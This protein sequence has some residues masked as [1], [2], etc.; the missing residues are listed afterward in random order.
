[1]TILKGSWLGIDVG[2]ARGKV[3]SF[4]LIE[5]DGHGGTTVCFEQGPARDPYPRINTRQA[6]IALAPDG[7]PWRRPTYL[8][9]EVEAEICAILDR[10]V[11]VGRWLESRGD[12]PSAV[13]VDAPV[14]FATCGT[15]RLTEQQ[16]TDTFET[17][18]RET[19]EAQL[20]EQSDAFL[21]INAF[22]KCVGLT[23]YR[24]LA[25]RV[26][27][28]LAGATLETIAA[29]TCDRDVISGRLRETFPSD[30]Y[31][32]ANGTAGTLSPE[33]RAVLRRLVE[34]DWQ[35]AGHESGQRPVNP[36]LDRLQATRKALR[37]ELDAG[38]KL[39][40]MRRRP[41]RAGDL[42]DAF[43]C[44]FTGCCE[45]HGGAELHGWSDDPADRRRLRAEGAILTV[46]RM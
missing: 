42:W 33:A 34:S 25:E 18:T 23:V 41:G 46:T 39:F 19:F 17:P 35:A 5:S 14:A 31:K 20:A 12:R 28:S 30:V 4:C 6:L 36:T 32:R 37:R 38:P 26:D 44:A 16:S 2:S 7:R 45:D 8:Q 43:T 27:A 21:R 3:C 22:W 29:L 1:M 10:A 15:S 11:V 40:E 9:E 24:H 13:A